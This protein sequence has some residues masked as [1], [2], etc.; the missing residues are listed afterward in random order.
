[1]QF[2]PPFALAFNP[3]V[4]TGGSP[5]VVNRGLSFTLASNGTAPSSANLLSSVGVNVG[6]PRDF[7]GRAL[8]APSQL[9]LDISYN[10]RGFAFSNGLF[11]SAL[12]SLVVNTFVEE[13]N[14]DGSFVRGFNSGESV[15]HRREPWYF[16][17]SDRWPLDENDFVVP[18]FGLITAQPRHFYRVFLDVHGE[19]RAAGFG[20][21]GSGAVLSVNVS[22]NFMNIWFS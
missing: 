4:V 14:P 2:R 6:I 11:N 15:M 17:G 18:Q 12:T 7:D 10:T 22:V 20:F 13:F 21:G 19:I 1:M 9:N 16:S 3:P 5:T 8:T